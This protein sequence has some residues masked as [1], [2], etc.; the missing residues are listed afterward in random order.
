V[1]CHNYGRYVGECV[2]SILSQ[3]LA[4]REAVEII[5]LDDGSTDGSWDEIASIARQTG[6][7]AV[8]NERNLG[9][10]A[11]ID[12]LIGLAAGTY[13]VVL[14]ADDQA[15]DRDAL[16]SQVD[17]L[18]ANPEA[19]IACGDYLLVDESGRPIGREHVDAPAVLP[20][21]DAFARLLLAN[22][23]PHS[24]TLVRHEAYR[25]LGTHDPAFHY[26][27]DWELWLRLTTRYGVARV[28]RAL[29]AYRMHRR[30]LRR[31][32]SLERT[33]PEFIAVLDQARSYSPLAPAVFERMRR[34]GIA[35]AQV[36]R[37]TVYL[38][39]GL[40]R[41]GLLDLR[42]AVR[43]DVRAIATWRVPRAFV[44]ALLSG[45]VGSRKEAL[46]G[47]LRRAIARRGWQ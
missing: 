17:A 1:P 18:M 33:V 24:G 3:S 42:A 21:R 35:N 14:D 46:L 40:F 43:A 39:R 8:R 16:R 4:T 31:T 32:G 25:R 9:H 22:F 29:Y 23:I 27:H 41:A 30:S 20:A 47:S 10:V 11:T 5:V 12:R 15:V 34:R 36:L 26:S 38:A 2:A 7:R 13:V 45:L 37:A 28:P 6:I 44:S 19:G